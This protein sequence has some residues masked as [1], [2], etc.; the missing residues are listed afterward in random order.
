M[1]KPDPGLGSWGLWATFCRYPQE[2]VSLLLSPAL[3]PEGP[4]T[5]SAKGGATGTPFSVCK[6]RPR[7]P[8]A[9]LESPGR[10][11]PISSWDPPPPL[12]PFTA[13]GPWEDSRWTR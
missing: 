9:L 2:Q 7:L 12:G 13:P 1:T 4:L 8:V 3:P 10:R 11:G 5:C 6:L